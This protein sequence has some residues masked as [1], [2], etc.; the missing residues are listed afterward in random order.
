MREPNGSPKYP[1][2]AELVARGRRATAETRRILDDMEQFAA[3]IQHEARTMR[4]VG[5]YPTQRN[6]A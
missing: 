6:V 4:G 1:T 5:P 2:L 3:D